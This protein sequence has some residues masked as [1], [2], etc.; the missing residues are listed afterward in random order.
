MVDVTRSLNLPQSMS[1][2]VSVLYTLYLPDKLWVMDK[3]EPY[4]PYTVFN[5]GSFYADT[6]KIY[7]P[8]DLITAAR[9]KIIQPG[10][11]SGIGEEQWAWMKLIGLIGEN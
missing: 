8:V 5:H 10:D 9:L 3:L 1:A 11:D 7:V 2:T 4:A 6:T